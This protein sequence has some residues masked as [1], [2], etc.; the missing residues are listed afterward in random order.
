LRSRPS[1]GSVSAGCARSA[2]DL[3]LRRLV[4]APVITVTSAANLIGRSF[5]H[6]NEAVAR[7]VE[8]GILQQVTVGR[9]NRGFEAPDIIAAFADL[10]RQPASP[11]GDTRTSEPVRS[12]PRRRQP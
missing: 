3:L 6:T 12:V 9:R 2:P 11:E 4:G 5:V 10:E 7:L 8:A 1:G